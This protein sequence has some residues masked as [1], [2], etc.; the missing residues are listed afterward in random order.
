DAFVQAAEE[1]GIGLIPSLFWQ[2][3]TIP[4]IVFEPINKWGEPDSDTIKF[5]RTYTRE[6]VS[7]YKDSPAIWAWEFGNEMNLEVDLPH[8]KPQVSVENG[9]PFMRT[10]A[11]RIS[12]N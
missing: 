8:H 9:T 12:T 5:M 7:R 10:G 2:I 4:D 1:E 6:V 3:N 11:D